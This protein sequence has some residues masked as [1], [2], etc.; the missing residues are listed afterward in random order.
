MQQAFEPGLS[1]V[2]GAPRHALGALL[3]GLGGGYLS[4]VSAG[5][6]VPFMT[7]GGGFIAIVIAML[8][9]GRPTWVVLGAFLFGIAWA[10]GNVDA[11]VTPN[12]EKVTPGAWDVPQ[13]A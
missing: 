6:F 12:I 11:D 13:K 4:I 3:A 2:V 8:G 10:L 5:V 9:R 7:Q 1:L